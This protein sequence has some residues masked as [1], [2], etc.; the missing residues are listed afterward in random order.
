MVTTSKRVARQRQVVDVAEPDLGIADAGAVEIGAGDREHA[1][2][3]VDADGAVAERRQQFEH[4]PGAGAEVE[5]AAEAAAADRLEDRRLDP[6]LG[7]VERPDRVPFPGIVGEVAVRGVGVVALD[8]RQPVAV[9]RQHRVVAVGERQEVAAEF[10]PGPGV[11][12]PVEHPRALR[13][14]GR[15]GRLRRG[16]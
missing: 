5:Q 9:A 6:V 8:R 14:S 7:D 11:G 16:A 13:D 10:R 1:R 3:G 2:R 12:Q 4:P 15:S